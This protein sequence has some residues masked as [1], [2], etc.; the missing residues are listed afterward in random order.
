MFSP[1]YSV[2]AKVCV[3]MRSRAESTRDIARQTL[4]KILAAIGVGHLGTILDHLKSTLI[5][6]YQVSNSPILS[7]SEGCGCGVPGM[8]R[9]DGL[10]NIVLGLGPGVPG[11]GE[12]IA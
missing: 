8:G 6:G 10:V 3:F 9:S 7:T 2:L 12:V 1:F 11:M 4:T 5:R